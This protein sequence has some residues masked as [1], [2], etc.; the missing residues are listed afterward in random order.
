MAFEREPVKQRTLIQL[1]L[2]HHRLLSCID[3]GTESA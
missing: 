1:P 3:G 2:A